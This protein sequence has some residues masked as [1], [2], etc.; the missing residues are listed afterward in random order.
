MIDLSLVPTSGVRLTV[1]YPE[2]GH[3][4]RGHVRIETVDDGSLRAWRRRD[5]IASGI[6][7]EVT[8][9]NA[10]VIEVKMSDGQVWLTSGCGCSQ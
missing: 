7:V 3:I 8:R 5:I 2:G 10:R 9:Q 1:Q 6:P 4:S